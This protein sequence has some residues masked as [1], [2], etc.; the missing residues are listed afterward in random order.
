MA[1]DGK[2]LTNKSSSG[3]KSLVD[4]K[5]QNKRLVIPQEDNGYMFITFSFKYFGQQRFFGIGEQDATWFVSLLDKMKELSGKTRKILESPTERK[6]YRFH[7]INWNAKKCP[8][9]IEDIDSVPQNIIENAEEIIFW[10][11]Q[12]SKSTGRV[13]GFFYDNIFYIKQDNYYI[14]PVLVNGQPGEI[15]T[16]IDG[17][18]SNCIVWCDENNHLMFYLSAYLEPEVLINYAENTTK[19]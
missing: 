6:A 15:Y 19:K 9:K 13:V 2:Q 8:I 7:P 12:L 17:T 5:S 4:N 1:K 10:Q 14:E 18:E 11:F 3:L 16:S